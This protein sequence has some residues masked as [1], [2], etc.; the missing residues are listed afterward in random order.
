MKGD[1]WKGIHR[2][3]IGALLLSMSAG[4]LALDLSWQPQVRVGIRSTDNVR[5]SSEEH[6]AAL[7]FDNG[8]GL[9]LKA[10]ADEWKSELS[11]SFNFRRFGIGDNL[12]ADEYGVK[13][14]H[15]WM[16]IDFLQTTLQADYQRDSTLTSELTDAGRQ[17]DV[18]LRDTLNLAPGVTWLVDEDDYLSANYA[19]SDVSFAS[20]GDRGLVDYTYQQVTL[21]ATHIYNDQLKVYLSPNVSL[22]DVPDVGSTTWTYGGKVGVN[23]VFAPDFAVDLGVGYAQSNIRFREQFVA[24]DPSRVP[25]FVLVTRNSTSSTGGP[26]ASA[27][28][29]KNF[30]YVRTKLDFNRQVSPTIRGAQSRSDEIVLTAERD[31]TPRLLVGFRGAYDMR[32]AEE[33]NVGG[34]ISELNREQALLGGSIAYRLTREIT[35]RSEYRFIRQNFGEDTNPV[36]VNALF[37]NL[38]YTGDPHF[39]RGL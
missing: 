23:Y 21:G 25:P 18:A 22:F 39:Y 38:F 20:A 33:E 28:F 17:N 37:L 26:I 24:V 16:P 13:S 1:M 35:L 27:T 32:S 19:Y 15:Q 31:I 11:P 34:S 9:Q 10:E 8:G 30:E 2:R 4:C 7:G 14:Q 3:L 36:Y 5:W 12:D 6:E 29:K